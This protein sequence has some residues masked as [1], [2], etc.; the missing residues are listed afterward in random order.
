MRDFFRDHA[1]ALLVSVYFVVMALLFSTA[2]PIFETPD[3]GGHFGTI[4]AILEDGA[5]PLLDPSVPMSESRALQAHHPPLY[6]LTALPLIAPFELADLNDYYQINP[7]NTVG[8]FSYNN[9]N[10]YLHRLT[11]RGDTHL[12]LRLVRG[13]SIFLSLGTLWLVYQAGIAL[14]DRKMVGLVA[15]AFVASLPTFVFISGGVSNDNL[16]TLL[17]AA[18][19]LWMVRAWQRSTIP[20]REGI[21]LGLILSG[22]A[23]T[24][25]NVVPLFG[26]V[27]LWLFIGAVLG[28]FTWRSVFQAGFLTLGMAAVLAGWWYLRNFQI[29]GDP[30]AM[31]ATNAIWSRGAAPSQWDAIWFEAQGVWDSFWL[32]L[33]SFNVRGPDWVYAYSRWLV[34]LSLIGV[35][36]AFWRERDWQLP[37]LFLLTVVMAVIVT[38]ILATREINV[39]QGRI[40]FPFLA[41]FAVGI[42]IGWRALLTERFMWIPLLPL[43]AITLATPF[44]ILPDAY[45]GLV[46]VAALPPEAQAINLQAETITVLGYHV[47]EE[48]LFSGDVA[49][50]DVYLQGQHPDD[51]VLFA[52]IV[53]PVSDVPVGG[54][55]VY[56]GMTYTSQFDPAQI[57][58]VRL[59]FTVNEARLTGFISRRMEFVLGWRILDPSDTD[60]MNVIPW[61]DANGNDIG[62]LRFAGIP[63]LNPEYT[64]PPADNLTEINFGDSFMLAGYTLSANELSAGG[65]LDITTNWRSLSN[66]T[67]D[68]V[69][70]MGLVDEAGQLIAQQDGDPAFFPTSGWQSGLA[71]SETRTIT[72]PPDI[73]S[74]TL[75]LYIAWYDRETG[76][77]LP[78]GDADAY[79]VEQEFLAQGQ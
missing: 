9:Q 52:K 68:W 2:T 48:V 27:Y 54:V 8:T 30:L 42:V 47:H 71:H 61:T 24:K 17:Y 7:L 6:Y 74:D 62:T 3:E 33:G 63:F 5:L 72:L 29:Y 13:F 36:I 46:P 18:G 16:A 20:L 70:T 60:I 23:L 64:P 4:T 50:M 76:A 28:R 44:S 78:V 66:P 79:F 31:E 67:Q 1:G 45:R 56:P 12:A 49:T 58:R 39:S 15:M 40:L 11:P 55:D 41:A 38:L 32:V 14:T 51:L 22:A 19:T 69:L 25:L 34:G 43:I 37:I 75:R 10:A 65:V 53:D 77:R 35:G 59:K 73:A 26:V 21:L 57:Y